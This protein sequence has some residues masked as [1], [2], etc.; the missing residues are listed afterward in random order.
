[1]ESSGRGSGDLVAS[2]RQEMGTGTSEFPHRPRPPRIR[3][4]GEHRWLEIGLKKRSKKTLTKCSNIAYVHWRDLNLSVSNPTVNWI[5]AAS[6]SSCGRCRT[7]RLDVLLW[8]SHHQWIRAFTTEDSLLIVN[9]WTLH[10]HKFDLWS[11]SD[12]QCPRL[13]DS[14]SRSPGTGAST[15]SPISLA[16]QG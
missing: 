6:E 10:A 14:R 1:M 16:H 3:W 4:P 7:D 5:I 8:W 9:I 13:S 15:P 11:L 12:C 2:D